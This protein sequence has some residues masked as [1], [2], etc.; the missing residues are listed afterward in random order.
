M[1]LRLGHEK[2]SS[3]IITLTDREDKEGQS[4]L[5][6]VFQ[7]DSQENGKIRNFRSLIVFFVRSGVYSELPLFRPVVR[8][9]V[10]EQTRY[11][12]Q[13]KMS[14]RPITLALRLKGV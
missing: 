10:G 6:A 3:E 14:S 5:L 1:P 8:P 2:F 9:P 13:K 11:L 4:I 12:D 7:H